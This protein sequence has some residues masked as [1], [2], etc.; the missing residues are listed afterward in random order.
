MS[1]PDSRAECALFCHT[2]SYLSIK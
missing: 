2:Y 1:E